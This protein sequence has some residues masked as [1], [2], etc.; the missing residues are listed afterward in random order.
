MGRTGSKGK[1]RPDRRRVIAAAVVLALAA[2]LL[3]RFWP[4]KQLE[5]PYLTAQHVAVLD[6]NTGKMV[7]EKEADTPRSPSSLTKL[8]TTYLILEEIQDRTLDWEDPVRITP[9]EAFTL[10]SRYGMEPGEVFSVRQLVAGTLLVSGCDCVQALVRLSGGEEAFV[11]RMNDQAEALGLEGSHFVNPTGIDAS[12]HYMTARDVARLAQ[13]LVEDHP[14]VLEFTS[15]RTM[16][17]DGRS[18]ENI[19]RLVGRLDGVLGL[20]SG[21]TTMGGFSLATYI[22]REDQRYLIVL[23]DSND[24]NSRFSETVTVIRALFGEE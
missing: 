24:D 17:I 7:Y 13:A 15:Q 18:F 3:W 19:H 11:Q 1:R 20:K 16:E 9:E 10:G 12:G 22:Q 14:E 2:L 21:T 8:M 6:L 23:L 5:L 4:Q